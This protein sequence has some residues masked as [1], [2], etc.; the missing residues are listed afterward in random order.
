MWLALFCVCTRLFC[1]DLLSIGAATPVDATSRALVVVVAVEATVALVVVGLP[2][3]VV[4][5]VAAAVTV[6]EVAAVVA[7]AAAALLVGPGVL[8]VGVAAAEVD[9]LVLWV[10]TSLENIFTL[11]PCG[12]NN[13]SVN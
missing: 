9:V 10:H 1:L 7:V 3:L 2:E 6:V 8:V 12:I 4:V 5:E 11:V 13:I